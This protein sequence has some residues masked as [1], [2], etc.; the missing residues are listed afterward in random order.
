MGACWQSE[1]EKTEVLNASA[2]VEYLSTRTSC[3]S[4]V[5]AFEVIHIQNKSLS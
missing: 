1:E 2:V 4:H 5:M 3:V